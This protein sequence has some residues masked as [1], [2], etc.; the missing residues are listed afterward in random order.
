MVG[1]VEVLSLQIFIDSDRGAMVEGSRSKA[2]LAAD[3]I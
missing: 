1:L 2:E 3:T